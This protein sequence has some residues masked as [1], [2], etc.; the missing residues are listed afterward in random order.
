MRGGTCGTH[1]S[2]VDRCSSPMGSRLLL[3][4]LSEPS[5]RPEVILSRLDT[6]EALFNSPSHAKACAAACSAMPDLQRIAA[7]AAAGSAKPRDC[8]AIRDSKETLEGLSKTLMSTDFPG[9]D[10][11]VGKIRIGEDTISLLKRSIAPAPPAHPRDGGVIADGYDKELDELRAL[12]KNAEGALREMEERER[13][14][15]GIQNLRI[16]FHRVHGFQIEISNGQLDKVPERFRRRQTLK[17]AERFT[18]DELSELE[19]KVLG[20]KEGALRREAELFLEIQKELSLAASSISECGLAVARADVASSLAMLASELGWT[21][22]VIETSG[23]PVLET[24]A[25]RHP[26][27]EAS[28]PEGSFV[29]NDFLLGPGRSTVLV[30]GPNM[31]GKSTLMRS[32]AVCVILAQAGSFVPAS[33]MRLTP[34]ERICARVGS[35]DDIASG[36]STFMVEMSE[37][38]YMLANSGPKTLCL[39]DEAGRGTSTYDGMAVAWACARRL[40]LKNRALTA[41]STHYFELTRLADGVPG[42]ANIHL[43]AE[44]SGGSVV[45]GHKASEGAAEGSFGIEVA[46]MAGIP[47]DAIEEARAFLEM[48]EKSS[49]PGSSVSKEAEKPTADHRIEW[50]SGAVGELDPDSM[51]PRQA[52]ELAYRI[53]A[54]L[55][56]RQV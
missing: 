4:M 42:M 37:M 22:P 34:M 18:T 33:K 2:S 39:V 15:T 5:S 54:I 3:S 21:R 30:T 50:L 29:P 45:F 43:S 28:L 51:T 1:F 19:T 10:E 56:G 40:H 48:E 12:D 20:A 53:R 31:G 38:A 16:E 46:R 32:A 24:F 25:M 41:F 14:A 27:V 44:R 49:P 55:D 17:N 9:R 13:Q 11:L 36:R 6:V 7:R 23:E 26:T 8:A 35:G 47:P 52:M